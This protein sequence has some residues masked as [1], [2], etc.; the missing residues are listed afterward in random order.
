MRWVL[1]SVPALWG[2]V[3]VAVKQVLR[4]LDAFQLVAI[5]FTMI[6]ALFGLLLV[7]RPDMRPK[8]DRKGWRAFAII[9]LFGVPGSQLTIV[10]A[11][12]FIHPSLASLFIT[13]SPAVAAILAPFFLPERVTKWQTVGFIVA[14]AGAVVIIVTGAGGASFDMNDI[15]GA[16]IGLGTPISWALFT[17]LLKQRSD[18]PPLAT[19]GLALLVGS[20]YLIPFLPTGWSA[21]FD[22]SLEA[23]LWLLYLAFFGTFGA[24]I[25]WFWSLKYLD[26]AETAAYTYLVPVFAL[27]SSL[28]VLGTGPPAVALIGAALV[29][30]GVGL[31]QLSRKN[32]PLAETP[33]EP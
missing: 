23:W 5:R 21:A 18:G 20:I 7:L 9:G 33:L 8:L 11:Q 32:R 1:I 24:T 25:I 14:F 26:A 28:L 6:A 10:Y 12:N 13:L 19:T 3:F 31:T 27:V 4:E 16:A 2:M 22:I 30:V 17:I 15:I 29:L